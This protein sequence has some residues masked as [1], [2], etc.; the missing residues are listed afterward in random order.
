MIRTRITYDD[1]A[2]RLMSVCSYRIRATIPG[3]ACRTELDADNDTYW[4]IAVDDLVYAS[5][6]RLYN[7]LS[8]LGCSVVLF[9]GDTLIAETPS[10]TLEAVR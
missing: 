3:L 1:T 4:H 5:A 8:S 9:F 6:A 10:S 7:Q 2:D